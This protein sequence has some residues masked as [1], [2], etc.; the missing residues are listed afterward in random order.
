MKP[1]DVMR[2]AAIRRGQIE[3]AMAGMEHRAKTDP[4]PY[5]RSISDS[6]LQEAKLALQAIKEHGARFMRGELGAEQDL[7]DLLA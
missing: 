7:I 5:W 4:S 6:S 2:H 3:K 1:E